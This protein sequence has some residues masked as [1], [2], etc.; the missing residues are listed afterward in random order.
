MAIV[1]ASPSPALILNV[2]AGLVPAR[3]KATTR[4]ATVWAQDK[5]RETIWKTRITASASP[6][7]MTQWKNHIS[8]SNFGIQVYKSVMI[9]SRTNP[10]DENMA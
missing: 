7:P 8:Y 1:I 10:T 5:L 9:T 2:G 4:V 3:T 6:P